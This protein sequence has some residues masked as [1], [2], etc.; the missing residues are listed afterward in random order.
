MAPLHRRGEGPGPRDAGGSGGPGGS[1]EGQAV[2]GNAGGF[3][4]AEERGRPPRLR[5]AG[6]VAAAS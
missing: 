3:I 2:P 4:A 1:R 5:A 6:L